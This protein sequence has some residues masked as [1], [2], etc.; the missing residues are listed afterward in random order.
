MK[1]LVSCMYISPLCECQHSTHACSTFELGFCQ[2]F[3]CDVQYYQYI[4]YRNMNVNSKFLILIYCY[5]VYMNK[6][7]IHTIILVH[8][9]NVL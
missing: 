9:T 8:F 5:S 2:S 3:R 1:L 6:I 4:D 7:N